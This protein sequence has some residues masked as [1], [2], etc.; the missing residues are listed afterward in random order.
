M[1][2]LLEKSF[3]NFHELRHCPSKDNIGHTVEWSAGYGAHSQ[4]QI[5]NAISTALALNAL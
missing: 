1:E 4:K 3:E 2:I 5:D